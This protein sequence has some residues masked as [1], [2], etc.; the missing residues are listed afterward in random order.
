MHAFH[1]KCPCNTN[2]VIQMINLQSL[3][4]NACPRLSQS[5]LLPRNGQPRRPTATQA[6]H[7]TQQ[8]LKRQGCISPQTTDTAVPRHQHQRQ[9]NSSPQQPSSTASR[10]GRQHHH[11]SIVQGP[12]TSSDR[13]GAQDGPGGGLGGGQQEQHATQEE[14][15]GWDEAVY[16]HYDSLGY[17]QQLV[18]LRQ[19]LT[20]DKIAQIR[21]TSTPDELQQLDL[22]LQDVQKLSDLEA[23]HHSSSHASSSHMTATM[24]GVQG[25]QASVPTPPVQPQMN[26]RRSSRR[27]NVASRLAEERQMAAAAAASAQPS[28]STDFYSYLQTEVFQG[29]DGEEMREILDTL[30]QAQVE[31]LASVYNEMRSFVHQPPEQLAQKYAELSSH[32]DALMAA[33]PEETVGMQ[34]QGPLQHSHHHQHQQPQQ[35]LHQNSQQNSQQGMA[36]VRSASERTIADPQG[37]GI[38]P[39]GSQGGLLTGEGG[40]GGD[41][42]GSRKGGVASGGGT[43]E[44]SWDPWVEQEGEEDGGGEL[45]QEEDQDPWQLQESHEEQ[46][47]G[48]NQEPVFHTGRKAGDVSGE[49]ASLRAKKGDA[50]QEELPPPQGLQQRWK[51]RVGR[52]RGALF[53]KKVS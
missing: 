3:Q 20:P 33:A 26:R 38:T 51:G 45:R 4:P 47:Q 39:Y 35:R 41:Q 21:A 29:A 23:A 22:V 28:I 46:V 49:Y 9:L 37:T 18:V 5:P 42:E 52:A 12:R 16:E 50:E 10:H 53:P 34:H 15:G 13:I 6:A 11:P 25:S 31:Q 30:G 14:E 48:S 43:S 36:A 2:Y 8:Q 32:M 27:I 44:L 7:A 40:C 17:E 24:L 1:Q 19:M